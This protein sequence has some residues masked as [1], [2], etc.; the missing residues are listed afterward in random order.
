MKVF[1][2]G[3][4]GFVGSTLVDRLNQEGITPYCLM[5]KTSSTLN[6]SNAKYT[7]V[8][9]DLSNI[10]KLKNLVH[11][12]DVIFHVAGAVAA[13]NR[14]GFYRAN[15]LGTKNLLL[16]AREAKSLKRFV[17][18]SSLA[19][20][21][22]SQPDRPKSEQDPVDPVS[23]YGWSKLEGE[24]EALAMAKEIPLTIVRPPAVYGPRDKGILTFF[25]IVKKGLLPELGW[26]STQERRYSFVH[27]EDL[28]EGILLAGKKTELPS[29][30][31]FFL[32]GEGNFRWD[33]AMA[34]IAKGLG[35]KTVRLPLPFT[36]LRAAAHTCSGISR[37]TGNPLP[38]SS[39]KIK[40][41]EAPSW[42]CSAE[43]AKKI[44][45][46]YP[47]WNLE[48]GLA[49]TAHWYKANQVL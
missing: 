2:T 43:K 49:A 38:F 45:G 24:K 15:V 26:N 4:S 46:F 32:S 30:E 34:L 37:L 10:E 25:Q 21:G 28:V 47:K 12:V 36:I 35:K 48:E 8:E 22:P 9:G 1:I 11:D 6:L 13:L 14:E 42:T 33:E 17:L 16:A 23:D 39:D 5:R 7:P 19:A 18:V 31:I 40:E 27:V 44:L 3:A 20:A 29:G 41:I